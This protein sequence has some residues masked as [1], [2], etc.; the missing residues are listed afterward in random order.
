M[1]SR[2]VI[3]TLVLSACTTPAIIATKSIQEGDR[4]NNANRYDEAIV[5]YE[6]YLR[7]SPQLGLYRNP[8]QEADVCRKVSHAY[9]TQG[10]Y[11]QS[12]A[13]LSRALAIDSTLATNGLEVIDDYRE[14][15]VVNAYMGDYP[16]AMRYLN[17]SLA[18]SEGMQRSAKD[19]KRTSLADTYLSLAQVSLTLGNF[20]EASHYGEKAL[21]L[22]K[23]IAGESTG[24]IECGLLLGVIERDRG[25][26][27]KAI[28]LIRDSERTSLEQGL[29]TAR[30]HQALG[31]IYFLQGESE[32]GIREKML[33]IEEA[34]KSQIK[35]Q[36]L[37]MYL[38]MGDAYQKLGDQ[39]KA[40]YFYQK[41]MA[42]KIHMDSDTLGFVPSS[43]MRFAE[44]EKAYHYYARAGAT[45]GMGLVSLRLGELRLQKNET[46][47]AL[48]MFR[49]ALE[50]FNK[51]GSNEGIAKTNLE[52]A[53][54]FIGKNEYLTASEHLQLARSATNQPDLL[55]QI[56]LRA[57]VIAENTGFTDVAYASYRNAINII[58]GMRANISIEEFK[59]LFANTKVEAYDRIIH[60]LLSNK[61]NGVT[62]AQAI[63]EAFNYNEQSRSRT[64]LDMLGNKKIAAKEIADTALL[65]KEQLLRLKIIHLAKRES[66]SDDADNDRS[67]AEEME[68]AYREYDL[69]LSTIKLNNPAYLTIINVQLPSVKD[70]Q[71]GL[72]AETAIVEYWVS[73]ASVT[74]WVLTKNE[75]VAKTVIVDNKD[76]QRLLRGCRNQI[77][78]R[79]EQ[80]VHQSLLRLREMLITPIMEHIRKYKNLVVVPHRGLHFL[81]FQA[82]ISEDRRFLVEDYIISYAPASSVLLYCLN[83]EQPTGIAFLGMA[84]ADL[85]IGNYSNL[86]GTKMEVELLSQ[87]HPQ[88]ESKYGQECEETYIKNNAHNFGYLHIATHGVFNEQE[89]TYS[90]LLMSPTEQDD[91]KLTV[92]EIFAMDIN[93]RFVTLSAC[94]TALGELSQGDELVGLSRA[95]IYA[96]SS[97]VLVSLWKVEDRSTALLMTRFHEYL[98]SGNTSAQAL[99]FA[100]RDLIH[101]KINAVHS[102]E[103]RSLDLGKLTSGINLNTI[104]DPFFWA[105]FVLVGNGSVK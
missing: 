67:I 46:D 32:D 21:T 71:R 44:A 90:Y 28:L 47:S 75:L 56:E 22:F 23:G 16:A 81:P 87:L 26:L 45:M 97:A 25:N 70:I 14:L 65:D 40:E 101:K 34:E 102:D 83:R 84:L 72:D 93:S 2:A 60:L 36:M 53:T 94:E 37:M 85:K 9:A 31:E 12:F 98:A 17:K 20:R 39:I 79:D 10:K 49:T 29:N 8:S 30:Q 89:P 33:A 73:D 69:V 5:N 24:R 99:C 95:F 105:P 77:S 57:G 66:N 42:V 86:P 19:L 41:A 68:E 76:L 50:A 43:N 80:T 35:P 11:R 88:A 6:Q 103:L 15:G 18:L 7:T 52:L 55:W 64:F 3:W 63:E 62:G 96:G 51:A 74:I 82:L 91:G 54:I 58:D 27:Q 78:N 59:T 1:A 4:M 92:Q 13:Y 61:P 48:L 104:D 100:Q 38:R